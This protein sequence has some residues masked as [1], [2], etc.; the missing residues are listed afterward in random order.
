MKNTIS[1]ITVATLGM[2][3]ITP[4]LQAHEH[5]GE[6][7]QMSRSHSRGVPVYS[8]RYLIGHDR[9]GNPIWGVRPVRQECRYVVRERYA[10]P[11][12]PTYRVE[13]RYGCTERQIF[14]GNVVIQGYIRR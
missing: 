12:P 1:A 6:R 5:H 13:S 9:W 3:G 4:E 8:E 14:G 11:C 2:L 7:V 10:T